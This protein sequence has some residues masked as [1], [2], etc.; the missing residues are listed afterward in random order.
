[1]PA[2][3]QI[4]IEDGATSIADGAFYNC[5]RMSSVS[6]P[7]SLANVGDEAFSNCSGLTNITLP[8]SVSCIGAKAFEECSSLE[9]VY[10][11]APTVP[12]TSA[13]AFTVEYLSDV[14]LHVQAS[15]IEDYKIKK[16]WLV[17]QTIVQANIFSLCL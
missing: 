13:D 11:Y 9:D 4:E 1:M 17:E 5:R 6:F 7:K 10:C 14:T 15:A 2:K 8:E 3:S 16:P 12:E